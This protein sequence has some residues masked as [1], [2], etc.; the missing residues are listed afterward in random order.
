[1]VVTVIINS[2][3]RADRKARAR[4]ER[5]K[6]GRRCRKVSEPNARHSLRLFLLHLNLRSPHRLLLLRRVAAVRNVVEALLAEIVI[7]SSDTAKFCSTSHAADITKVARPWVT[8]HRVAIAAA[9]VLLRHVLY[10]A[11]RRVH[12]I[13]RRVRQCVAKCDTLIDTVYDESNL[14]RFR[15]PQAPDDVAAF[16]AT[17]RARVCTPTVI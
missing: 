13:L 6:V 15:I 10:D 11:V 8:L 1:L 12:L 5:L 14:T 17:R 16:P 7:A 4:N 2:D 9:L 3:S